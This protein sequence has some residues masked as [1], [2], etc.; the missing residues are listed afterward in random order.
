MLQNLCLYSTK[1]RLFHNFIFF[2]VQITLAFF[3]NTPLKF[4]YQPRCLK[5]KA[6]C[7]IKDTN[8]SISIYNTKTSQWNSI[9]TEITAAHLE[10]TKN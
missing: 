1:Y 8:N 6:M 4:K 7:P 10:S 2:S 5:V 3:I 9:L